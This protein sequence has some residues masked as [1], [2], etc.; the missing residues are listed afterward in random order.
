M[1]DSFQAIAEEHVAR[2][3]Q[4]GRAKRTISKTEWLLSFAYPTLGNRRIETI[5]APEILAVP[6][7]VEKRGRYE[8]ARR[9]RSTIGSVFR[10]AIAT[11]RAEFDPTVGLR[12]ALIRPKFMPRAAITDPDA[13]G[14]L[15][16]AID[17]FD[18]QP[19]TRAAL[20]LLALLFPRP[21][22]LRFARWPEFDLDKA[23]WSIPPERMK[24]RR[25]HRMPLSLQAVAILKKLREGTGDGALLFP[26]LRSMARPISDNTFNA[27]LRRMG[28]AKEQATAHGFRAT[29]SSLLNES[30]KWHPD[31]I[32]RQLAHVEGDE[33]RRAYACAEYWEER[34]KMMQW[35]ADY[36]DQLKSVQSVEAPPTSTGKRVHSRD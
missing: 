1:A 30:G 2:L 18:G 14:A 35:W 32:E 36:L 21:G 29:A 15:L 13:F 3:K 19:S 34:L 6:R 20:Q 31:A 4:E 12:D 26:S 24:M 10:H 9:L 5:K 33:V 11:A 17:D 16:R 27:A 25:P 22:E 28:Y 7:L 8:S 23:I